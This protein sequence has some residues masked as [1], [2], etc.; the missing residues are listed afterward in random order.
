MY[1]LERLYLGVPPKPQSKMAIFTPPINPFS[2]SLIIFLLCFVNASAE[3]E[4]F[5]KHYLTMDFEDKPAVTPADGASS[6][7]EAEEKLRTRD[8]EQA[9]TGDL[10]LE[11]AE[12]SKFEKR[13]MYASPFASL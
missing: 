7:T 3:Y 13:T 5:P 12:D 6:S 4:A 8:L 1:D 2:Y 11:E 9:S 10:L